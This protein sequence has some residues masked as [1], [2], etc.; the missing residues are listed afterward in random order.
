MLQAMIVLLSSS[1]DMP[2]PGVSADSD[3]K[4]LDLYG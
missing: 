4:D 1:F 3:A 2:P